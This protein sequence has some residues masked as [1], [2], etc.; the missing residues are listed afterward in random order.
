[1]RAVS[2]PFYD[3]GNSS[4]FFASVLHDLSFDE[5][6][7]VY[8]NAHDGNGPLFVNDC[9]RAKPYIKV[10]CLGNDSYN[11]MSAFTRRITK[12]MHPSFAK[13][14]GKR[15]EFLLELEEAING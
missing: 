12:V 11:T 2:W 15:Q 3:F 9:I 8:V 6:R 13:R 5:T 7:A 10:I 14:F 4:E 1:M